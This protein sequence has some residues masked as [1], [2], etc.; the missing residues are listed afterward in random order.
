MIHKEHSYGMGD[1]NGFQRRSF[2]CL[3]RLHQHTLFI[4]SRDVLDDGGW[5]FILREN[6]PLVDSSLAVRGDEVVLGRVDGYTVDLILLEVN[7]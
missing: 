4:S 2:D 7:D 6:I 5:S 3:D 1:F